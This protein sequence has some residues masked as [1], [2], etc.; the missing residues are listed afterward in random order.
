MPEL[1]DVEVLRRYVEATSLDR[2]IVHVDVPSPELLRTV[3]KRDLMRQLTGRR[4][5]STRRHGKH[6]FVG[7]DGDAWLW[8]HFGMTGSLQYLSG[9]EPAPPH[10]R[11]LF[12]FDTGHRLAFDCQ[13]KF[14]RV[15]LVHDVDE[16]VA[17]LRLGPDALDLGAAAFR[18]RLAQRRGAVKAVLIDQEVI[19]GV[20][21]IYAD[22]ILFH[23][24]L[25][26][27]TEVSRLDDRALHRLSRATQHVLTNAIAYRADVGLM[28]TSWLLP[29]R[30]KRGN[31]CPR[32]HR[33][34]ATLSVRGRTTWLCPGCQPRLRSR[35]HSAT[36]RGLRR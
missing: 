24:G 7:T 25:H 10:T 5:T 11:V 26:P 21:N 3:S 36:A 6:L 35:R 16:I 19:A 1:P 27:E 29:H 18:D 17:R 9:D 31:Q 23:A 20:G 33:V 2:P 34:L 8:L 22:E 15:G 13:R 14:G 30:G 28:P 12:A 4:F 32:C